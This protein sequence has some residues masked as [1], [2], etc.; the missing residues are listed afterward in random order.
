ME[1]D[2][3]MEEVKMTFSQYAG[4]F[5]QNIK[6]I[7]WRNVAIFGMFETA[8]TF[9]DWCEMA[10]YDIGFWQRKEVLRKMSTLAASVE[11]WQKLYEVAKDNNEIR[12]LAAQHLSSS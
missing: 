5:C 12:E 11:E 1:G 7:K 8:V 2:K 3:Q 4:M 6:D 9:A 10:S